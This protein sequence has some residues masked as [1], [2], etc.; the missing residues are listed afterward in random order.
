M[1][2]SISALVKQMQLLQANMN[3]TLSGGF[4]SLGSSDPQYLTGAHNIDYCVNSGNCSD[5]TNDTG[6]KNTGKCNKVVNT[7]SSGYYDNAAE[8]IVKN[9]QCHNTS[10]CGGD[11]NPAA[12]HD[13][14]CA[15]Y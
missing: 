14:K 9:Q 6:C 4:I 7:G 12:C 2:N 10:R 8:A 13:T 3:G 11:T 15:A 1:E 5:T